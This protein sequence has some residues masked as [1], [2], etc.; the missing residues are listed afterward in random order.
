MPLE[1]QNRWIIFVTSRNIQISP[2][3]EITKLMPAINK[4]SVSICLSMPRTETNLVKG[5]LVGLCSQAD[6]G[7][8]F[9]I[10]QIYESYDCANKMQIEQCW[11]IPQT[12]L[13]SEQRNWKQKVLQEN[14]KNVKKRFRLNIDVRKEKEDS[15][16]SATETKI[17]FVKDHLNFSSQCSP[18][19][20]SL[21]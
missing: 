2:L 18:W 17:V 11:A 3:T 20:I 4:V 16:L 10:I 7:G 9:K 5:D 21:R 19:G 8:I 14:L 1:E 15:G 13:Y 12:V 6:F